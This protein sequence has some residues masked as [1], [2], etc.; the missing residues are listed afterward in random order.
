MT[1]PVPYPADTRAKGWR[2]E[3][4][5]ERIEQSDTWALAPAD[6]KPWLLMLWLSA[7]RQE[8]CGSL[9][10]EDELIAV[11]IGMPMKTFAKVR[12][13]LMRG[14]WEASDGR[15]YHD[16]VTKRV[17]EMLAAREAERRRKAEYR[18]RKEA[19]R[20]GLSHGTDDGHQQDDTRSDTGR[21]GTGTGTGT[22]T[23]K[24][25]NHHHAR[26][27]AGSVGVDGQSPTKAGEVCR[28]IKARKVADVNPS[29][30]EL[31]ALIAKGVPVE[32]FEAAADIC[33][34]ATP[35]KGFAYL[36]GIVKRQLGEAAQ[37]ASGVGMPEKPWD[38][39]RSTIEAKGEELCLGRWNEH[40]LSVSRETFP[41]YTARIRR[42]VEQRQG[43]PA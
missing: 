23:G 43:V 41:Q 5:H 17:L 9:P 15:L 8:P 18:Q 14:W 36:L 4:D 1:R 3:L 26:T 16:T 35:P 33:A 22:S 30:P 37:I 29:N 19:E 6:V 27:T 24:E 10:N 38:E 31:V 11:R 28:A 42:A 13:K 7:W 20:T 40:D 34:K 12:S 25:E 39:N 2:F 21:D 32:T